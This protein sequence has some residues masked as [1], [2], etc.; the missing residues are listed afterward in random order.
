MG[1][2]VSPGVN[3]GLTSSLK[4][5]NLNTDESVMQVFVESQLIWE[6][7]HFMSESSDQVCV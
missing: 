2:Q 5:R 7:T 4:S 6:K 3:G 1:C